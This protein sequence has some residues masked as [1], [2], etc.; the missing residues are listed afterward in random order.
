MPTLSLAL[1][2]ILLGVP[3]VV[4]DVRHLVLRRALPRWWLMTLGGFAL[5]LLMVRLVEETRLVRA[6]PLLLEHALGVAWV[7][8]GALT[9]GAAGGQRRRAIPVTVAAVFVGVAAL[10]APHAFR[11]AFVHGHNLVAILLWVLLF[12]RCRSLAWPVVALI[13]VGASVLASGVL[14]PVTVRHGVLSLLGLHL[15]AAADWLAPGLPDRWA[16]GLTAAF[17]FLQSVHYAIWLVAIP[18]DDARVEGPATFRMT[19]R[20]LTRDLGSRALWAGVMLTGLVLV[21]ALVALARTRVLVLSLATFH[22]WMELALLAFF[23]ARGE[24]LSAA[25]SARPGP[26]PLRHGVPAA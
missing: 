12:R 6:A 3:H 11:L 25:T 9:G 19:W 7:V 17:A 21:G 22:A 4:S 8:C 26:A 20:G 10:G 1:A 23:V 5:A 16:L 2:P 18:Q 13:I 24:G 14:L 15:F